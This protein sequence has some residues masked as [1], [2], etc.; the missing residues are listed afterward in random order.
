MDNISYLFWAYAI[1]WIA[2]F[3]YVYRLFKKS[4][5]L[6]R[7]IETLKDSLLTMKNSHGKSREQK[8]R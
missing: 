7:E 5:E 8:G 1:F 3:V 2:L 6:R 4:K